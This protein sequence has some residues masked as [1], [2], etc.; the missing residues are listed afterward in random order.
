VNKV[1]QIITDRI[2]KLLEEGTI[3]WKKPWHGGDA[4]QNLVSKRAY[5][6]VNVF[7]LGA[8]HYPSPWWLTFRQ[9]KELG[10]GIKQ[11]EHPTPVVFWKRWEVEDVKDGE[12]VKKEIPILR[13]YN[14]F[15]SDQCW[16]IAE[17]VPKVEE[18][19]DFR[20]IEACEHVTANMPNR[21]EIRQEE[22]RAYY[23]P[24]FDYVNMPK[25]ELF[26]GPELYYV[27]LFHELTHSTGHE[28]RVGRDRK[29]WAETLFRSES[30]S[31]EELVAEMGAAFLAGHCR[32][33]QRTEAHSASYIA[34]W[35]KRLRNDPKMV[36]M[37][38]SQ[39]QKAADFILNRVTA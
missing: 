37:A 4:P 24:L 39:A 3:P 28:G 19:P 23:H 6:G 17:K 14:V 21:P 30:Y 13:Y 26:E 18:K 33:E 25:P 12:L 32:I 5:R 16:G 9:A 34:G 27:V 38:A 1:Y 10:G 22:S 31:Q 8:Q 11:G 35:L 36:V 20:P 7:L 29:A 15:N 2:V